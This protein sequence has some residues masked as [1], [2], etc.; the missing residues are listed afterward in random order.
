MKIMIK[1]YDSTK[2]QYDWIELNTDKHSI[3]G[4]V[5]DLLNEGNSGIKS[6]LMNH[7]MVVEVKTIKE[8]EKQKGSMINYARKML[9][10]Y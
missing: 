8:F 3:L 7:D 4:E 1:K 2:A 9:G 5:D 10:K 6:P